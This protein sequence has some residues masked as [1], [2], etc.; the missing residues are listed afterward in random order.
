MTAPTQ[1]TDAP[2]RPDA[3]MDLLNGLRATAL[4]PSYEAAAEE[5]GR[6]GVLRK[7]RGWVL[8]ALVLVGLF[9]G[10]ALG[11]QLR[12]AP[13]VAQERAHL[14]ERIS[15]TESDIDALRSRVVVLNDEVSALG[16][17]AGALTADEQ[18]LGDALGMAV[19]TARVVGPGV[20]VTLDDGAD[21]SVQGSQVVDADLRMVV[22]SLRALGAEAV[23][24]NGRRLSVRTAIR[25]A[26]DAI[27]V[28]YRSLVRPY[29]I[30]AIGDAD[31]L[32]GGFPGS[33][34]GHWV[35][36][37]TQHYGVVWSITRVNDLS[38]L[39][40]PG[41]DVDQARKAN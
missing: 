15:T 6:R 5:R 31:A 19:G 17:S 28:D 25:N 33:E 30:E 23:S 18:A 32:D 38:M 27:T 13:A 35:E 16:L 14:I 39:A 29:V 22:N 8:V 9:L 34:G 40:D 4:D 10:V 21:T 11:H 26:G 2:R 3:S 37:L 36:G 12:A 7:Q 1:Q 20:R 41:L 24:I